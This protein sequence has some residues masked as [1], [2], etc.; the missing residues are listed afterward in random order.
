MEVNPLQVSLSDV[1]KPCER[2]IDYIK[3]YDDIYALAYTS[4]GLGQIKTFKIP[5][6]GSSIKEIS[7]CLL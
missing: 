4:S 6:D 7:Y 5:Y 1:I 2:L 3:V